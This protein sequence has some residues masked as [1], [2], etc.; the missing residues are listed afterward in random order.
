MLRILIAEDDL[1]I[2]DMTEHLLTECEQDIAKVAE[3]DAD[4]PAQ[5]VR[6]IAIKVS[7]SAIWYF[8]G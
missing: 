8:K 1:M 6:P 3:K 2:A 5:S 7:H 4:S